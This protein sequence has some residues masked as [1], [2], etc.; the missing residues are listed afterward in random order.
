MKKYI[1]LVFALMA[2]VSCQKELVEQYVN[3]QY[4]EYSVNADANTF[5]VGVDSYAEWQV[6]EDSDWIEVE[7]VDDKT[8]S[9][10]I[11]QNVSSEERHATIK[12]F[13]E[14]VTSELTVKQSYKVFNGKFADLTQLGLSAVMSPN[15]RYALG[16][17]L[18]METFRS[19]PLIMDLETGEIKKIDTGSSVYT[20]N[21]VND[22]G[23]TIVVT[24][25]GKA[26]V[27]RNGESVAVNY[28][29]GFTAAEILAISS[30]GNT[31]V[32]NLLDA[33]RQPTPAIWENGEVR[34]LPMPKTNPLGGQ[35][36]GGIKVRGASADC[37]VIYG[38]E[39]ATLGLVYWVNGNLVDPGSSEA[40]VKTVLVD[41]FGRLQERDVACTVNVNEEFM[42]ISPNGKY[43]AV[44]YTDYVQE[45][46]GVAAAIYDYPALINT[47]TGE[48]KIIKTDIPSA[49]GLTADDDGLVFGGTP[50]SGYNKGYVFNA[51]DNS[52]Q[53][54]GDWFRQTHGIVI[55]GDRLVQ[56]VSSDGKTFLGRKRDGAFQ[57]WYLKLEYFI[58]FCK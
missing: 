55:D 35:L 38:T 19:N 20:V 51:S 54:I 12:V 26:A 27:Y 24:L 57:S 8:I 42:C 3:L 31:W 44:K 1:Y 41:F 45:E 13:T 15:G 58:S 25:L 22:D 18:D 9:V 37:S 14:T 50:A 43:I 30:D 47:E 11:Q 23:N 46:E 2:V 36:T 29:S 16:T 4:S 48:V 28:P 53:T 5:T 39:P 49:I 17:A 56:K 52:Y 33:R 40:T 7:A 10:S 21:A 6:S 34:T 32:G